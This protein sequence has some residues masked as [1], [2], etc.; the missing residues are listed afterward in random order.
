MYLIITIILASALLIYNFYNTNI[1]YNLSQHPNTRILLEPI[2]KLIN[3]Q[4]PVYQNI[5]DIQIKQHALDLHADL[6]TAKLYITIENQAK[7][8]Q[9]LPNIKITF[10][11]LNKQLIS[12]NIITPAQYYNPD[13]TPIDH[14]KTFYINPK[15]ILQI[16]INLQK[17]NINILDNKY[18][19]E[20]YSIT[21]LP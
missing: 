6:N 12:A 21:L 19:F 3:Y 10:T 13:Y 2:Y 18:K 1:L 15:Q 20:N 17:L 9:N 5:N 16:V 14:T 4:I 8:K 7:F 11:D